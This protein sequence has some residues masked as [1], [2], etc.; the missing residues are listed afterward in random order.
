[1]RKLEY[2]LKIIH[3]IKSLQW[4]IN[5]LNK[6][7]LKHLAYVIE[8]NVGKNCYTPLTL[9]MNFLIEAL[10]FAQNKFPIPFT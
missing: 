2:Q 9:L 4:I 5:F 6:Q 10:K 3:Q 1:M 8:S 7:G